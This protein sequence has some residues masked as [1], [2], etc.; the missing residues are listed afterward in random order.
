V[1]DIHSLVGFEPAIPA[2]ERRQTH[3]LDRRATGISPNHTF[4]IH[5]ILDI[6]TREFGKPIEKLRRHD[7]SVIPMA[8]LDMTVTGRSYIVTGKNTISAFFSVTK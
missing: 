4:K 5:I 7:D 8:I 1:T 2:S 3:A 6:N